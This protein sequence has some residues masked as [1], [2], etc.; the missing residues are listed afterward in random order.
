MYFF[1]RRVLEMQGPTRLKQNTQ[2]DK[3][4]TN[5]ERKINLAPLS[6]NKK[7]QDDGITRLKIVGEIHSK[8][9]QAL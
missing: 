9:R 5:I 6:K 2:E 7:C 3:N 8:G 1:L 4:N